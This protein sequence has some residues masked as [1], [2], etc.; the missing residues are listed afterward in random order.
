MQLVST[1]V[2]RILLVNECLELL[3][4]H[5]YLG[6]GCSC[7][8]ALLALRLNPQW[9]MY[10]SEIDPFNYQMAVRNVEQN[11]LQERIHSNNQ[12]I[13]LILS[14]HSFQW[15]KWIHPLYSLAWLI[16]VLIMIFSC[17]IHRFSPM[18]WNT[19]AS[20]WHDQV[21]DHRRIRSIQLPMSNRS[22]K[23]AAK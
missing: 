20:K 19:K 10:V 3:L 16:E 17:A 4:C 9:A 13:L 6:S 11:A 12:L 5:S 1:S 7:I 14:K 2:W 22:T 8:H 23:R 18:H 21:I 15:Y